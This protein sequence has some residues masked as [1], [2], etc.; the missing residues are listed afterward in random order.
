MNAKMDDS[1]KKGVNYMTE[2]K[3]SLNLSG[4]AYETKK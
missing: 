1:N 3:F 2:S 4:F